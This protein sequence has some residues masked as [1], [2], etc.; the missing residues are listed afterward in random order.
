VS[1]LYLTP[2]ESEIMALSKKDKSAAAA[3]AAASGVNTTGMS[4]REKPLNWRLVKS[5]GALE[6]AQL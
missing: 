5:N 1:I 3:A 6:R 2:C 4:D